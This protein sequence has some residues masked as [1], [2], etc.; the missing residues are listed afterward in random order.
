MQKRAS[1]FSLV[2]IAVVLLS[3]ACVKKPEKGVT[4][5]NVNTDIVF[6]V[7]LP[8]GAPANIVTPAQ[9]PAESSRNLGQFSFARKFSGPGS[10][11][12]ACGT[13]PVSA[14]APEEASLNANGTPPQGSYLWKRDGT[15]EFT[16]VPGRPFAVKGFER[17]QIRNVQRI[18]D[19]EFRFEMLQPDLFA[20]FII[21]TT[22]KVRTNAA[23]ARPPGVPDQRTGEPDRGIAIEKIDHLDPKTGQPIGENAF[24]PRP[25]VLVLPL[26]AFQGERFQAL[27][28][29]PNTRSQLAIDGFVPK[30]QLVDACGSLIDGW[31][32]EATRTFTSGAGSFQDKWH[33]VFAT[34][35]G[36]LPILEFAEGQDVNGKKSMTITIGQTNPDAA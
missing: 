33:M 5:Q 27:G 18:S 3:A 12:Q 32:L 36:G 31:K 23:S 22:F 34:Q 19:G 2:S 16:T 30:R 20:S 14:H 35:K 29:D 6:G 24:N 13:A 21:A 7:K 17:R 15:L 8:A 26:P 9:E 1:A 11:S 4:L 28:I 10:A 25:P